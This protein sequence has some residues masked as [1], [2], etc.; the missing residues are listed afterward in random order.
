MCGGGRADCI[1]EYVGRVKSVNLEVDRLSRILGEGKP[2]ALADVANLFEAIGAIQNEFATAL[3]R[4]GG[5]S[6]RRECAPASAA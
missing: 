4:T 3:I 2:V 5:E 1:G 6:L